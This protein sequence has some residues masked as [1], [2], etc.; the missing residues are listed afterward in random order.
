MYDWFASNMKIILFKKN[1]LSR[2]FLNSML[3]YN[4]NYSIII[5]IIIYADYFF[6][7]FLI[8]FLFPNFPPKIDANQ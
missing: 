5:I 4:F 6:I 1:I 2:K 8:F 3:I 7:K